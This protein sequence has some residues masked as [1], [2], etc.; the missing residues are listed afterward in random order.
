MVLE[1]AKELL[2][3]WNTAFLRF[4][5]RPTLLLRLSWV[6]ISIYYGANKVIIF[7]YN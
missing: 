2:T 1:T 6:Q 7:Q 5:K 3:N 4:R